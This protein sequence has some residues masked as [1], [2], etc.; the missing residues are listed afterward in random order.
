MA[1]N[2]VASFISGTFANAGKPPAETE[3]NGQ[4]KPPSLAEQRAEKR[5]FDTVNETA[6]A[7]RFGGIG[8]NMQSIDKAKDQLANAPSPK[9]I[10]YKTGMTSKEQ[11]GALEQERNSF[12]SQVPALKEAGLITDEQASDLLGQ[13]AVGINRAKES[14]RNR[15]KELK[16]FFKDTVKSN[17]VPPVKVRPADATAG[18]AELGYQ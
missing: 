12:I 8:L 17:N 13:Y 18:M 6:Y 2:Q 14:V 15:A 1:V 10:A 11:V 7:G 16:A 3:A 5:F 4:P 9:V